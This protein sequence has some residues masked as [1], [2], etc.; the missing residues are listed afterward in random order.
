MAKKSKNGNRK[1][2]EVAVVSVFGAAPLLE[3]E[4]MKDYNALLVQL[5][6]AVKP[7]D[8]LEEIWVRDCADLCWDTLRLR[9]QKAELINANLHRGLQIVL[10][11]LCPESEASDLTSSWSLRDEEAIEKINELL[12]AGNLSMEAVKAQTVAEI[13][14]KIERIDHMIS[15][16]EM[17]RNVTLREL[18]RRRGVFARALREAADNVQDGEFVE[19]EP[20][21]PDAETPQLEI[22]E[23]AA[24]ESEQE[25]AHDV[26]QEPPYSSVA[27]VNSTMRSSFS[28][29]LIGC[30][31]NFIS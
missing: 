5:R 13:I 12:E 25:T 18:E 2:V 9:R 22:E 7:A 15:T 29:S 3:G 27:A 10:E 21:Q 24:D 19:L 14:D 16:S 30:T 6:D 28:R 4:R 31:H 11:T 20:P 23:V 8:F 1:S 26:E 17:R